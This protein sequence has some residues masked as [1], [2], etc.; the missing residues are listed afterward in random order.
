MNYDDLM[1][2]RESAYED[3][4]RDGLR[5]AEAAALAEWEQGYDEGYAAA[6][7]KIVA[8]IHSTLASLVK[9]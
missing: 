3:G 8:L 7:E 1:E 5:E 6:H 2:Q 9:V 4:Y